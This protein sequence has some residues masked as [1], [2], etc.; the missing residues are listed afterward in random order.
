MVVLSSLFIERK[1]LGRVMCL[2]SESCLL[3]H[4]WQHRRWRWL[5]QVH[6]RRQP[7]E[8]EGVKEEMRKMDR[9]RESRGGIGP[10]SCTS[11]L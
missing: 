10:L 6:R 9:V 11:G 5:Q 3:R 7:P 2:W 1:V 8:E 4:R